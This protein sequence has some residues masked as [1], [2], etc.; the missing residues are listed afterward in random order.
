MRRGDS[1]V[2]I[3]AEY[4]VR[5]SQFCQALNVVIVKVTFFFL[6]YPS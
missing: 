1:I 3:F 4:V 5:L 2:Q 6:L